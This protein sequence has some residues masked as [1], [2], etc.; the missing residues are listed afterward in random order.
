MFTSLQS[1][2]VDLVQSLQVCAHVLA[3]V[4]PAW[5]WEVECLCSALQ[6]LPQRATRRI[7]QDSGFETYISSV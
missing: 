5:P 7:P 1:L 2:N 3:N 6:A 4:E